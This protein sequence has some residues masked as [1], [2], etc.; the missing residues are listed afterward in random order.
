MNAGEKRHFL[1]GFQPMEILLTLMVPGLAVSESSS[2]AGPGHLVGEEAGSIGRDAAGHGR[3]EASVQA[4]DALRGGDL[5]EGVDRSREFGVAVI[6]HLENALY[7]VCWVDEGP[8]RGSGE[9]AG[10]HERAPSER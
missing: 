6:V 3:P 10:R 2:Q 7:D 1:A 8:E 5:P 4:L 9:A